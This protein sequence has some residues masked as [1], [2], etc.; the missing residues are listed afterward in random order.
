MLARASSLF[1]G[2][3]KMHEDMVFRMIY[4]VIVF[5]FVMALRGVEIVTVGAA[6]PNW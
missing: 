6:G 1:L 2:S 3:A 4:E 5:F